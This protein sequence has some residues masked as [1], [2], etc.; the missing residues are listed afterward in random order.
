MPPE[1]RVRGGTSAGFPARPRAGERL[2][3]IR[4]GESTSVPS[5]LLG[6]QR[7]RSPTAATDWTQPGF[8]LDVEISPGAA[9]RTYA[10][11]PQHF[12]VPLIDAS[13]FGKGSPLQP[14]TTV[15]CSS[16]LAPDVVVILSYICQE[17]G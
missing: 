7:L 2:G 15:S 1:Q 16:S 17:L 14:E 9:N 3:C 8:V 10:E 4:A 11:T 5:Q 13:R 6:K 12:S